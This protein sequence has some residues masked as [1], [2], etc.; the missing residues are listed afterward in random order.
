MTLEGCL[1]VTER[2]FSMMLDMSTLGG[3]RPIK[4]N[5]MGKFTQVQLL[6]VSN[7]SQ[8]KGKLSLKDHSHTKS[9]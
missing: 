7:S 3:G 6:V 2:V 8:T 4:K 9:F 5:R 1:R